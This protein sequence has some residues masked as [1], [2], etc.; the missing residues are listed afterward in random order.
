MLS[1]KFYRNLHARDLLDTFLVS[2]VTSVLAVRF[3]LY[4]TGYPQIGGGSLHIAHMLWGG[5]LMM[6]AIV[7]ALSFI[8]VRSRQ[9]AAVL[10]GVGFGV[11]IDELGKFI[12]K[13]NDYFFEPTIGLI[14][15]TFVIL[16]LAFNFFTRA[17]RLTPR[18]Y[19]LNVLAE[20]EEA[21]AH[22]MDRT[23]KSR[24]HALLNSSDQNDPLTKHLRK[25]V[26]TIEIIPREKPGPITRWLKKIDRAYSRFWKMR[27]SNIY[28][29]VLFVI[30]VI[31]LAGGALYTVYANLDDV[32]GLFDGIA[33]YGEELLIGQLISSLVAAGF[34][35]YGLSKLSESRLAAFEQFRR[36]TLINIYLTQFFVFARVQFDALPGFIFNL[37]LLLLISFVLSQE[38]RLGKRY[39]QR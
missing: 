2:A 32:R 10:G 25:F 18:E 39:A 13:D 34:V 21:I 9:A 28:V 6:A 19:Q 5:L 22:D 11:F 23:E 38:A 17:Q 3:Y 33:T 16:Y 12:T 26:D 27:A 24:L 20:L 15:A 7:I 1:H 8:G 35:L 37:L 4:V 36:A 29:S 14:Y 30:E 31:L